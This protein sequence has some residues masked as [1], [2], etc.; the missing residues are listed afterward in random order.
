[1]T[2]VC[3]SAQ[4]TVHRTFQRM[5]HSNPILGW[6]HCC[7]RIVGSSRLSGHKGTKSNIGALKYSL[8]RQNFG[9]M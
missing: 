2:L 6:F 7:Q 1:M 9:C 8:M 5:E 3:R 4:R